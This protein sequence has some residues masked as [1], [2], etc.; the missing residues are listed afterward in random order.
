MSVAPPAGST[1]N[2]NPN[3]RKVAEELERLFD[4]RCST[5]PGHGRTGEA[6]GIDVWVAPFRQ[7]ANKE[8]EALGDRIQKYVEAN[9]ER[10]GVDYMIWWNWMKENADTPWFSYE[11]YAFEWPGGDP[12]PETRRH[13]DHDHIQC[14]PGFVYRAPGG[15]DGKT[16]AEKAA[17][18][19]RYFA[20]NY[21]QYGP[22]EPIGETL[23]D[24]CRNHTGS[25]PLWVSTAAAL[26]EQESGG[27]N[28]FGCDWGPEWT[29]EPPYCRV[30]VTRARVKRL[31]ENY[32]KGGGQNG[33]GYCQLTTMAYVLRAEK[34]GGA[35][36]AKNNM[37]VGF[38]LLNDLLASYDY[39]NALEAYNDGNGRWNNP[40]NPYDLQFAA[41]HRA[42]KNRLN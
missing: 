5:Y 41:K 29:D 15:H 20:N 24:V 34:L 38:N 40:D 33:V 32:R 31:I 42:W 7:K 22:Y 6:W 18:I 37:I 12:D 28:V 23:V 3:T 19:D 13:L 11:P 35:H 26:V 21:K 9:W 17:I 4:V 10:L 39:L 36:V 16:D 30:R 25:D 14:T 8:Q 1:R 27:R 2:W